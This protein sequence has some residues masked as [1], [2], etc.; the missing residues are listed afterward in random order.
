MVTILLVPL[1]SLLAL[2]PDLVLRRITPTTPEQLF[3]AS[4]PTWTLR[5]LVLSLVLVP[6][7]GIPELGVLERLLH[8]QGPSP[9]PVLEWN[10]LDLEVQ[11]EETLEHSSEQGHQLETRSPHLV[12]PNATPTEKKPAARHDHRPLHL[13]AAS[14]RLVL[15]T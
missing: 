13:P 5:G 8:E 4:L 1:L 7:R 12:A 15:L 11:S 14:R 6:D 2:G 9:A 10:L 3:L